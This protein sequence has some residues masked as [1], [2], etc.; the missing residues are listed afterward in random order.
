MQNVLSTIWETGG[1]QACVIR[2]NVFQ[3]IEIKSPL[4]SVCRDTFWSFVYKFIA[5]RVFLLNAGDY[6]NLNIETR[7]AYRRLV[8]S[9]GRAPDCCAGGRGFEP[10]T[11]PT[12][13]VLK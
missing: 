7:T 3:S 10:Q 12:L 9:V 8:S 4:G 1:V 5:F 2:S 11:G 6:Q 13:G